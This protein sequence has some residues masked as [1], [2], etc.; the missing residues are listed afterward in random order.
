MQVMIKFS[1]LTKTKL[2]LVNW[3]D[4]ELLRALII[5]FCDETLDFHLYLS[6]KSLK[7]FEFDLLGL[8]LRYLKIVFEFYKKESI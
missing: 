5:Y 1:C 8:N 4:F 3:E 2:Q 7:V 6:L